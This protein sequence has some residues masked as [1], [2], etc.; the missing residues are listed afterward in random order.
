MLNKIKPILL[1]TVNK[2]GWF[3]LNLVDKKEN[4]RIFVENK[5]NGTIIFKTYKN[6]QFS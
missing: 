3:L 2:N 6:T 4:I 5:N 1:T